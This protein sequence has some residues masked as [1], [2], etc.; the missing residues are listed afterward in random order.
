MSNIKDAINEINKDYNFPG[1]AKL[2]N[3][4]QSKYPFSKD[5]IVKA[6]KSDVNAQLMIPRTSPK[7]QGHI[8]SLAINELMQL[9]IFDMQRYK[10]DNKVG[11]I[12]YPYMLVLIDVFSR[13]AYVE[14]LEDKTKEPVLETFKKLVDKV[15]AKQSPSKVL[16]E[17]TKSYSIHQILSDNEG[18]FQ[19]TI[20]E[21][22]L[23]DNNMVLTMNAKHDHRVLGIIDNLARR[24][25]TILTK[26]FLF[27]KNKRWVDKIDHIIN[28]YNK[29]PNLSLDGLSPAQA[30]KPEN[31]DKIVRINMMKKESN[32]RTSD[33]QVGDK[34]RKYILL[35]KEITKASMEPNWSE[36][37]FKVIRVQGETIFLDD[38]SKYKR[39]NLL[40]V[41]DD[42]T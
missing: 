7:V 26:T 20:F 42:T 13:Y 1:L 8:T 32:K 5:E 15:M 31:F 18:S 23:E 19:S 25:K 38:G 21:K 28:I 40:K 27:N 39:Y 41:P 4:V 3:L 24:I 37:I 12:T 10:N 34:V 36:K 6:V 9:D 29:T 33:L 17:K 11:D 16:K 2:I 22:Y 35:R 30:L 14:P